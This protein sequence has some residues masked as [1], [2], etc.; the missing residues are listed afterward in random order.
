MASIISLRKPLHAILDDNGS[1]RRKF[2]D[3]ITLSCL[4]TI[5]LGQP[6]EVWKTRMGRQRAET[7]AQAFW[8]IMR[9]GGVRAFYKGTGP[10]LVESATKGG[11]LLVTKDAMETS[12]E[13]AGAASTTAAFVG[14]AFGGVTQTIVM[15]PCTFLVTALVLGN[16]KHD[17]ASSVMWRTWLTKGLAGFYPGGSAI[18]ARQASNWASRA[19]FTEAVRMRIARVV[20][21][22][23]KA[24]LSISEEC[25]AG[26]IG[27]VLSCW[28]HPFEVA[29][30]EMQA[31][32]LHGEQHQS[33]LQV[34]RS[35]H[36]EH[37]L[38]GL[39][40]GL[41]PR[42]GTNVWLT[43][44][45]LSGAN[46]VMKQT[47]GEGTDQRAKAVERTMTGRTIVVGNHVQ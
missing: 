13:K 21:G 27:G 2:I 14:G 5:T 16:N 3:G 38:Q 25:A 42:M 4:S 7:T 24:R 15:G 44:F 31:R 40:Q 39:F 1:T 20:H 30:I 47:P 45:M 34:L 8:Q 41:L 36:A 35:V 46:I 28:N 32:A 22:D 26:I 17:T 6:F 9:S 11:V 29:R 33:M 23:A 43:L 18:A 12:L 37:G 19:G 10:K